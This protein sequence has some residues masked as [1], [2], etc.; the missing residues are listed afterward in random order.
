MKVNEKVEQITQRKEKELQV[1]YRTQYLRDKKLLKEQM[2]TQLKS[3][4]D[5]MK[6]DLDKKLGEAAR[7]KA[8]E[9]IKIR[10]LTEQK[11]QLEKHLTEVNHKQ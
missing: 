7:L 5:S 6:A 4:M 9:Q 8:M 10:K 1:K 2:D 11:N 3:Q